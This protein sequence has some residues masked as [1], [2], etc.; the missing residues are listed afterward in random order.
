MS[1]MPILLG[2][3]F[4]AFVVPAATADDT[5]QWNGLSHHF[6]HDR[7]PICPIDGE[8][9][10]VAL[11]T[12]R[13][14]V[15]SVQ[16][17]VDDGAPTWISADYAYDRGPYA[18]WIA[19]IPASSPTGS[20]EYYF[21]VTDGADTDYLGPNGPS[22]GMPASGW[23]IDFATLSH[24]PLGAT[25]T[26]DGGAVFKVWAP[27][28]STA[29]VAGQ[30]NGWS[31][32]ATP[33]TKSGEY[34]TRKV[35]Q[36]INPYQQY[37]Y[38]FNGNTWRPDAR[39]RAQ[40]PGD[41]N[42]SFVINPNAHN[43]GD[44]AFNPPPFEEM[45]L[46]ELHVGTFSGYN[47][48]LNRMGRFRDIVDRH[49]DHLLYL[50]VNTIELMPITEFDYHQSWGYN[51]VNNW[52][53]EEAYGNPEDLKYTIDVLHENGIAVVLDVVFNHFSYSGNFMWE[54]D[55]SQIYFDDPACDTPWGSQAA[56]WKQ[57]VQDY[58]IGA[59]AHWLDEYHVDGFR[60]DA[61]SYMRDPLGCYPAGWTLMQ[62]IN[63]MMDNRYIDKINMAEELPDNGWITKATADNGAGFDSQWHDLYNDD[64]RQAIF[65]AG[66]GNPNMSKVRD[67]LLGRLNDGSGSYI[68]AWGQ[69][70]TRLVNYIESHDEADDARLAVAI[71][72]GDPYSVWAKGRS[73]LVQGLTILAPGIPLFLQGGEWM[74][75]IPFGSGSEHRIDWSK[76]VSR[77]P[78][79]QFFRDVISV[80]KSNCGFRSDA[81]VDVFHVNESSNIL[82]MH[83]WDLAGNDLVAVAN[84]GNND[85][86]GYSIA[87]PQ[88]GTWYE[89]LNSQAAVY[90]G[91][92]VGNGGSIVASSVAPHSALLTIPQMGLLV[93][94]HEDPPGRDS[95]LDVDG[96]VD[97]VD[98]SLLQQ[99][100]P[101]YGCGTGSDL[102]E[103]GRV[104][105]DDWTV[106]ESNFTGP[107]Q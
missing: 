25:P 84:F 24:A 48:G 78:I 100:M 19:T 81:G 96:D 21:E 77:G 50:G 47:D 86:Y 61:T 79:V 97:L 15:A 89:I 38:V 99:S 75:S 69:S 28:P 33:M 106:M 49:L 102:N 31:S 10:T 65:D 14:D 45:I 26:T 12:Y 80:R 20:L 93:F 90:D 62:D 72:S 104:S 105:A 35:D 17:Y 2:L 16:V 54:Y 107:L 52:A 82:A 39:G 53:V 64:V 85:H 9:F 46:Y 103:D 18:I 94:R 73:K 5:V 29:N 44:Q 101:T 30:F 70:T 41:N 11:Q 74:E 56:F 6:A 60:M 59:I 37:K 92:S 7:R 91:N 34:F 68:T 23:T 27:T 76:A 42:N 32:T 22:D 58:F 40:N 1:S 83:R 57:E 95:D 87:F 55:S 66:F 13:F 8:S 4:A 43:W 98:F 63:D 3:T 88:G 51:P 67:A 71:D 36:V